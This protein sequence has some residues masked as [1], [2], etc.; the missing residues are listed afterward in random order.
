MIGSLRSTWSTVPG[1]LRLHRPAGERDL[2]GPW[3]RQDTGKLSATGLKLGNEYNPFSPW[4]PNSKAVHQKDWYLN[5]GSVLFPYLAEM[6]I[7]GRRSQGLWNQSPVLQSWLPARTFLELLLQD[8]CPTCPLSL[9]VP[10]LPPPLIH[11]HQDLSMVI[12]MLRVGMKPRS[13][14]YLQVP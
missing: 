8:P 2:S 6:L 7:S 14:S 4:R 10:F 13:P 1:Q 9:H 11:H 5:W 12:L 3:A